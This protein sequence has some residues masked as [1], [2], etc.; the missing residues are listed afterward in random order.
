[1][2]TKVS[3]QTHTNGATATTQGDKLRRIRAF[4]VCFF[5]T[6]HRKVMGSY[7]VLERT[8][9]A[10]QITT[11]HNSANASKIYLEVHLYLETD[12]FYSVVFLKFDVKL[13][14]VIS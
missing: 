6:L 4:S 13:S 14:T 9:I 5:F 11:C 10:E 3:V 8:K 7:D 2:G 1:M 12:S